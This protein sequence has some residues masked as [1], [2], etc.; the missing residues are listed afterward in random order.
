MKKVAAI[1]LMLLLLSALAYAQ[2][3]TT[4][5]LS[6]D[7][8]GNAIFD[9]M[10]T[11]IQDE[12]DL[13]DISGEVT[14]SG[15]LVTGII[16]DQALAA[17]MDTTLNLVMDGTTATGD[18]RLSSISWCLLLL[19]VCTILDLLLVFWSWRQLSL[20]RSARSPSLPTVWGSTVWCMG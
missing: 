9:F 15:A 6:F 4:L 10:S 18:I 8:S 14:E 11:E 16:V 2:E 7:S 19:P 5:R 13:V 20:T 3:E 12:S 1:P 17:Q